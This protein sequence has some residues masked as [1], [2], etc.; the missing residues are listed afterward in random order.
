ALGFFADA[1]GAAGALAEG[2]EL[3]A[4]HGA[5]GHDLDLVESR[6][7]HGE[8]PLDPHAVGSL[9]H[10]E[11]LAVPAPAPRDHR[12]LEDLD[13]LVVALD[14]ADV[15]AARVPRLERREVLP[16]LLGLDL[17]DRVHGGWN[18][19]FYRS[20]RR[21]SR[22]MA[23]ALRTERWFQGVVPRIGSRTSSARPR[24]S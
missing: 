12:P 5:A 6:G 18:L 16:K 3:R 13:P 7:V 8:R 2:V 22:M 19:H 1:R 10:G 20:R 17:V 11:H 14:D 9:A 21:R 4:A 24:T 15:N 23:A